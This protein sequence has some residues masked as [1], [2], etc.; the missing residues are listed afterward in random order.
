MSWTP[1]RVTRPDQERDRHVHRRVRLWLPLRAE[2][3]V[4]RLVR[5]SPYD[6]QNRR[7]TTFALIEVMPEADDDVAI[8]LNGTRS[9]PTP[10]VP[11]ARGPALPED[12]VGIRLT[13]IPTGIVVSCRNER[14]A[15]QSRRSRS[16][17]SVP[18]S[19]NLEFEKREE[20]SQ[21]LRGGT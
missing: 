17:S 18:R 4:H 12:R 10:S 21:K 20:E 9:R 7:Q 1:R 13:H 2:R 14:S 16:A 8:E 3:G 15:T 11:R 19:W 6:A 5:I